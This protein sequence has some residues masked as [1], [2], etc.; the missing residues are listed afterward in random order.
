MII[1][2]AYFVLKNKFQKFKLFLEIFLLFFN[3]SKMSFFEKLFFIHLTDLLSP[4]SKILS[5]TYFLFLLISSELKSV[6][7]KYF[8]NIKS[9]IN[10]L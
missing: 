3:V 2:N 8:F 6:S 4:M 9:I 10:K 5:K 7:Q 1:Q